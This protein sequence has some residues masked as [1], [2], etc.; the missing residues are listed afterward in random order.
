MSVPHVEQKW[1]VIVLPEAMVCA[2]LN[3]FQTFSWPRKCLRWLLAMLKLDANMDAVILW[4]S[5]QLQ[6]NVLS[7]PGPSVG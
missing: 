1:F 5:E 2:W 4:Q 6:T 7:R 3:V